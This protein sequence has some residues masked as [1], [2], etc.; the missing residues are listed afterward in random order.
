VGWVLFTGWI[1]GGGWL[2][3]VGFSLFSVEGGFCGFCA[4]V[5]GLHFRCHC[6]DGGFFG[7][8]LVLRWAIRAF[9]VP[10]HV[11]FLPVDCV[12]AFWTAVCLGPCSVPSRGLAIAA[13]SVCGH[14]YRALFMNMYARNAHVRRVSSN[15]SF[16]LMYFFGYFSYSTT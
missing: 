3:V 6:F 13:V 11:R 7:V 5:L 4:S 8:A 12:W 10:G 1:S 14:R 2:F 16:D 9:L 15:L